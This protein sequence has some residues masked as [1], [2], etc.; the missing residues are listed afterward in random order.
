MTPEQKE[1]TYHAALGTFSLGGSFEMDDTEPWLTVTRTGGSVAGELLGF[2]LNYEMGMPGIGMATPVS[3][4]PGP[5]KVYWTRYEE[6]VQRNLYQFYADMM[7]AE[8]GEWPEF[9]F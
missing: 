2:E 3:D 9:E 5:G 4:W 8:Q 6:G 7:R 1:R